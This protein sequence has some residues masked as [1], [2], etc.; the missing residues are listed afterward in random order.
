MIR[1]PPR[2]TLFPYTTLF[3]SL[4]IAV[5]IAA[6]MDDF[7][8]FVDENGRGAVL[9][10]QAPIKFFLGFEI[11]PAGV[12]LLGGHSESAVSMALPGR[13]AR[14]SGGVGEARRFFLKK[15][16][17]AGLRGEEISSGANTFGRF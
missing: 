14:K 15:I 7:E 4:E 9:A 13:A 11:A 16:V 17:R 12:G 8:V 2:S 10:K 1:R 5:D 3:R 6:S